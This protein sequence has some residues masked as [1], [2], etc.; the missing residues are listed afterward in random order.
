MAGT[1][2][3]VSAAFAMNAIS[4]F[5]S[6]LISVGVIGT[7][8]S[9]KIVMDLAENKLR[10]LNISNDKLVGFVLINYNQRVRIYT[11]LINDRTKLSTL[12]YGYNIKK[13][14]EQKI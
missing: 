4:F 13:K 8:K 9:D 12:E 2:I 10:R 6:Q 14:K 7:S 1:E 5:D 3:K 11:A